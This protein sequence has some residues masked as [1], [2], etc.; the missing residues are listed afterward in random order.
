MTDIV[1]MPTEIPEG[2]RAAHFALAKRLL[3]ESA[4][5]RHALANGFASRAMAG[6]CGSR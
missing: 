6:R 2:Q 4:L 5:E 1:C 3:N